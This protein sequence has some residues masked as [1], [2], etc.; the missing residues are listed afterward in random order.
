MFA[1][2][3]SWLAISELNDGH[4]IITTIRDIN[5]IVF[6]KYLGL[7]SLISEKYIFFM[8]QA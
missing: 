6:V 4:E 1:T 3:V 2:D 5:W 7:P 8:A